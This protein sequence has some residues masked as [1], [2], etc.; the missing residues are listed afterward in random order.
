MVVAP[1]SSAAGQ[2]ALLELMADDNSL[3]ISALDG[4]FPLSPFL[5]KNAAYTLLKAPLLGGKTVSIN[6]LTSFKIVVANTS[7]L[8]CFLH[9]IYCLR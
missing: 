5:F 7:R 2:F 6:T 8:L 1:I 9:S 4:M 3:T